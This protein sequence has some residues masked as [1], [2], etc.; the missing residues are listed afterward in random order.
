MHLLTDNSFVLILLAAPLLIA[1]QVYF[2][3]QKMSEPE[4]MFR[5]L[6]GL[7]E[8]R[9]RALSA[10]REWLDQHD[11]HYHTTYQFGAI[12]SVLFRQKDSPRFFSFYF[13]KQLTFSIETYFDEVN[14]TC[15]DTGTSGSTGMLPQRP[16][17]YQQSFP[18]ASPEVAWQRH[19]EAE[20]YITGRFG[21][22]YQ[23]LKMPYEQILMKALRL[24]MQFIRRIPFYPFRAL[25]WY[26]VT[27]SRMANR[28]IQQQ[29]P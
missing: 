2:L 29:F 25:Y 5:P 9:E 19:L 17:Q 15:L 21:I 14:C 10:Y 4:K 7:S 16:N 12:Q 18:G 13:H 11:L 26:A 1:A 6:P 24:R 3:V 20:S 8:E 23:V 22:K 28:S 27:R